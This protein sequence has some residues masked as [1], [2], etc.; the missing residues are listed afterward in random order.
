M[1]YN[2][3]VQFTSIDSVIQLRDADHMDAARELVQS[4]VIS[5]QMARKLVDVVFQQMQFDRPTDNRGILIVGNYGTGK[6]HLLSVLSAIAEHVDLMGDLTHTG[7]RENASAIAGKFKVVRVEIG[8]VTR[9]LRDI[10]LDELSTA[11]DRWGT[12]FSFPP[13]GEITNNKNLL[14]QAVGAFRERYPDTG[15]LLVVD[16]LLDYLR[17]REQRAMILDLGFLR[18]LGEVATAC[19][20]RFIGGLQETLFENPRFAFVADQ[21]RRVRDRFEQ[22]NIA[23]EDITYVVSQRLLKK[24][25]SQREW[26][27]AYLRRFAPLYRALGDRSEEFVDLFPIH[28]SYVETFENLTIAEKRQ[29]LKTFS[30]AIHSILT[31]PV[32]EDQPALISFDHYWE[33]IQNDASL[34]SLDDIA[35]VLEKSA[36]LEGLIR[37][38]YTRPALQ[39]MAIRI[40]HALSVHRLSTAN[41]LLPVGLTAEGLRDGLFLYVRMPQEN[42]HAEFLLEQVQV[43]LREII[44]TV[45]GQFITFNSENGQYYLD[46]NRVVDFDQ[47]IIDRGNAIDRFDLNIYY[48]DA[49][50]QTLNLSDTTYLTGHNLWFYELPWV[51]HKVTRPGYLFFGPPDE[52][53]TAQPPR[54][55]YIYILPPFLNREWHDERL[56]DEV[57]VYLSGLDKDFENRVRIYAGARAMAH[58]STEYRMEYSNKADEHFRTL[59]RWLRENML[60]KLHLIHQGVDEP[61]Q[62]VITRLRSTSSGSLDDLLRIVSSYL[63]APDFADRYPEYPRFSRLTQPVTENSRSNSATEALRLL[64]GRGRTNLALGVLD[65]LGLLDNLGNIRPSQSQYAKY[66]LQVLTD[67]AEGQVVNRGDVIEM[68]AGGLQPVEKDVNFRLEP[69]WLVVLLFALVYNGDIV[70]SLDGREEIDAASIDRVL[71]RAMADL[72]NFRFFKRPRGIPINTW[73]AVFEGL[74]VQPGLIRDENT[75][76]QAV[77]ELQRTVQS[78]LGAL[79]PLSDQIQRGLEIWNHSVFTDRF[80]LTVESGVVVSGDNPETSFSVTEL[81]PS[82]RGYKQFLE[83]L[84]RYNT[85]GRLRNLRYTASDVASAVEQR[86]IT[87]RTRRLVDLLGQLQPQT[88]YLVEAMANLLPENTWVQR[89]QVVQKETIALLRRFGKGEADFDLPTV[90][91]ELSQLRSEYVSTY[92]E[93]HR[94]MALTAAGD[95]LRQRLYRDPRF[96]SVQALVRI[97]MF[98]RSGELETWKQQLTRPLSCREF[99]EGAL[100]STP[101]C[102]YCH[103]RPAQRMTDVNADNLVRG[104]D[105]RLSAMLKNWRQA[106][107]AALTSPAAQASLT[108][109]TAVERQPIDAFLAQDEEADRLPANFVVSVVQALRGIQVVTLSVESLVDAL[110]AGGL[111]ATRD[112]VLARIRSFVDAQM[113][114]HDV[115]TTRLTLD[116]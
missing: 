20:F 70:V 116:R 31:K 32:P 57:I 103:M 10:L 64:C 55:F 11:L 105:N 92:S 62:T 26:I 98:S 29:V 91:R 60:Q 84:S 24:S 46:L 106:L 18:E 44:R 71:T 47:K 45:Q 115:P 99:H 108:A 101:T 83:E 95:D 73:V 28:P 13:A 76:E 52:R 81:L 54:D 21:L 37:Q 65:G 35:R 75:R 39:G 48:F 100:V 38:N 6:S 53:T 97:D 9:S 78:E 114:G 16:E 87:Q 111:P 104:L 5:E 43:A 90:L 33:F 67:R 72:T 19:P 112:D 63:L 51:D 14:I 93:L 77:I 7:V 107:R 34:R 85:V 94:R 36:I 58:E 69:E 56:S 30:S 61:V 59:N 82:L 23:R 40:I 66:F 2:E 49:L 110:K 41:I 96:E 74:G 22:V 80:T 42:A 50:R 88:S 12:P 25:P 8:S 86:M 15:I 79:V 1:L 68:V 113:R 89:A 27:R 3:L 102:P 109:M 4:Y 17:T